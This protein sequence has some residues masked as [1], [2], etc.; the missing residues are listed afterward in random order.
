[1]SPT[2]IF[3]PAPAPAASIL[4]L[5]MF[6]LGITGLMFVV[7]CSLLTRKS[8][9]T[10]ILLRGISPKGTGSGLTGE[11]IVLAAASAIRL[12]LDLA[13]LPCVLGN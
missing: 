7:V 2:T 1:M 9:S 12:D 8:G 11:V 5:S 10:P 6:V 3:A 13:V 4:G